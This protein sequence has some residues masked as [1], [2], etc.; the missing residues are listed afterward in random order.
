MYNCSMQPSAFLIIGVSGSGKSTLGRALARELGW[1]FSDADDFHSVESIAKMTAGIPLTDADRAPWLASLNRRLV[2][3]LAR[4]YHPVL[5]CSALKEK[6]RSQ[7]LEGVKGVAVIYLK[8]SYELIR[9]RLLAREGHYMKENMLQSQFEAL[10]EPAEAVVLHVGMP[11][12]RMLDTI[13]TT[14]P[15]LERSLK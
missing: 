15:T 3:T 14:Y 2:S 8:G 4:G 9:S 6:Y 11:L 5:A 13:F 10:E 1:V 12:D 7:L